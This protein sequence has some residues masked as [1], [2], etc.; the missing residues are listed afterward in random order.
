[1]ALAETAAHADLADGQEILELGCGWGSL[2]LWMAERFPNARITAVSN[3]SS[4]RAY[5]EDQAAA[6]GLGNL[7]VVTADMNHFEPVGT[8]DRVVSVEMFEHMSNWPG[9][10]GRIR[11]WLRPDGRLFLA[12]LQP[13]HARP[14]AF[15]TED[16][17]DWIA[18]AFLHRR[19]HA[20]PQPHPPRRGAL[21]HRG[22]LALVRHALRPHGRRLAR[23]LRCQHGQDR[24]GAARRP[25]A[26]T[27]PL[28]RRRWRLFF[29]ATSGL[30]GAIGG[31]E[32]GVS[33]YRLKPLAR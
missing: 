13:R 15:E 2:S 17:A 30:F 14:T 12:R 16:K 4:Q 10:L 5:I 1:L 18:L 6:R 22:G 24:A 31:N 3:S 7:R 26:P 21:R 28:W 20:Q 11:R 9:L 8:F 33:H 29:L 32:W 23:Q 19:H 27:G 25:T